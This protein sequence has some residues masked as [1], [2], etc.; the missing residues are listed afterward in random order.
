MLE[1]RARGAKCQRLG[2]KSPVSLR[3]GYMTPRGPMAGDR[4][5]G[6]ART[7]DIVPRESGDK[8]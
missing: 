5:P 2:S 3:T 1:G 8:E 7:R 4:I 6:S